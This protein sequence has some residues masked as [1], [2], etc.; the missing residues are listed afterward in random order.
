MNIFF[1]LP[2]LFLFELMVFKLNVFVGEFPN[3]RILQ[4]VNF[5]GFHIGP[6]P[7]NYP[8]AL[9]LRAKPKTIHL[10][11]IADRIKT[12]MAIWKSSLLLIAWR[13]QLVKSMVQNLLIH[14]IPI[15]AFPSALLKDLKKW[16][17]KFIWS[18]D[19]THRKLVIVSWNKMCL[20]LS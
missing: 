8:G 10:Q 18:W 2:H 4:I 15:Y 17:R 19:I 3:A 12:K 14:T 11:P 20:P 5:L 13:V 6:F 7:F 1:I 9:I 16:T